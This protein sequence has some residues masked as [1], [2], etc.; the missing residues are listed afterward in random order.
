[1][2]SNML[3]KCQQQAG[4]VEYAELTSTEQGGRGGYTVCCDSID[5]RRERVQDV[6]SQQGKNSTIYRVSVNQQG[7]KVQYVEPV[8]ASRR[9][10]VEYLFNK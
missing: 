3:S 10:D 8:S 2:S 9:G 7:R 4:S 6:F 1:M 5:Y